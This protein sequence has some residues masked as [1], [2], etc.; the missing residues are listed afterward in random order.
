MITK[1]LTSTLLLAFATLGSSVGCAYGD[2]GEGEAFGGEAVDTAQ[3][4]FVSEVW[5]YVRTQATTGTFVATANY[6]RN[7]S[8]DMFA[9]PDSTGINV[10]NTVTQ[11]GTGVY[12]VRFPNIGT[13][14]GG[15]VH[16]TAYGSTSNRCKVGGWG[17]SSGGVNATVRCF[18]WNG[19]P[20]N[21][22]FSA[23]Y[24]RKSGTGS[25]QEAYLW[26]NNATASSYTPSATYSFNSTGATN[27]IVRNS[28]GNYTVTLPGMTMSGGTVQVTAY[29]SDSRHCKTFNWR[30]SGSSAQASVA[31]FDTNGNPADSRYTLSFAR[32]TD[33]RGGASYSYAYADR[34]TTASYTPTLSYQKG[35]IGGDLGDVATDITVTRTAVGRYTVTL[36]G[37]SALGSNVQ[38]TGFGLGGDHCKV[39]SWTGSAS[40]TQASVACFNS[41]GGAADERF[42]ISYTDDKW[43]IL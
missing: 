25:T 35:E 31:C 39:V 19:T 17:N 20:V 2:A 24:V 5:G 28:V 33:L 3:Q 4:A 29:G 43:L 6:S 30:Q 7:S 23:S 1:K 16:V 8:G 22:L 9:G 27:T 18:A 34:S 42:V 32:N 15:T 26:A 14:A 10:D 21:T 40:S 38:V 36:P 13:A 12:S 37:M 41:T 11:T